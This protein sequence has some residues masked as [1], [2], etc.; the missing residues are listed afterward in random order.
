MPEPK[1]QQLV[2]EVLQQ[3][4]LRGISQKHLGVQS[5]LGEVAISR[6]KSAHDA[7]LS[8]LVQLGQAVG[9]KLIWVEDSNLAEQVAKGDLFE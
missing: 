9:L 7:R 3:A 2:T 6:L 4:R 5:S 1:L 8:T